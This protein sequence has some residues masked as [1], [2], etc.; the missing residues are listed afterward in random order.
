MNLHSSKSKWAYRI[1]SNKSRTYFT[2]ILAHILPAIY[3]QNIPQEVVCFHGLET[4]ERIMQVA[5][6]AKILHCLFVWFCIIL[7]HIVLYVTE[8]IIKKCQYMR[9]YFMINHNQ[10]KHL[11]YLWS[12]NVN[13]LHTRILPR[14]PQKSSFV[15]LF[16]S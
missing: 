15:W 12:S 8:Y 6:D 4:F 1:Y 13:D 10:S 2:W 9:Y 5:I 14:I 7:A 3:T 16:Y 11:K